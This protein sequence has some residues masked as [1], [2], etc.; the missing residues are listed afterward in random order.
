VNLYMVG[1][2]VA[3]VIVVNGQYVGILGPKQLGQTG[4]GLFDIGACERAVVVVRGF[5]GHARVAIAQELEP[6][7]AQDLGRGLRFG[8][9]SLRER[10]TGLERVGRELSQLTACRHDEDDAMTFCLRARHCAPGCD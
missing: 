8:N 4:R 6:V 1:M 2:S 3:S 9:A 7:D 10:L 5:A